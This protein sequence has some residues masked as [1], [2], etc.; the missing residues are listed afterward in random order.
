MRFNTVTAFHRLRMI[1]LADLVDVWRRGNTVVV[2]PR[3]GVSE[4]Q[5]A[6]ALSPGGTAIAEPAEACEAFFARV[7][8]DS[9]VRYASSIDVELHHPDE[10][11]SWS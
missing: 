5:L 11:L 10:H 7:F 4:I 6:A 8:A 3:R 2:V 1:G 9:N